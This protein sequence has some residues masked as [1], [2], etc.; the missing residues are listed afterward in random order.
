MVITSANFFISVVFTFICVAFVNVF[1]K[2]FIC[3]KCSEIGFIEQKD[4]S[5]FREIR[6]NRRARWLRGNARDT[7]SGGLM[8][9]SRC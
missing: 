7:L 6:T 5:G 3:A 2:G 1:S 8:F 9:K 4:I